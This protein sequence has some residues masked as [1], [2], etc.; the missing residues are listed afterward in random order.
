MKKILYAVGLSLVV[1][2]LLFSAIGCVEGPAGSQGEQGIQGATGEAGKD[3]ISITWFGDYPTA[4]M[5]NPNEND[6]YYNTTDGVSYI[7]DGGAWDVLV[8][9]GAAGTP[10]TWMG[11]AA[12]A[13]TSWRVLNYAYYNSTAGTSY[14][15]DGNS[16]EILAK[17]GTPCDVTRLAKLEAWAIALN[18]WAA[19]QP[20]DWTEYPVYAP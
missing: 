1:L 18:T 10:I 4:P 19:T 13:P 16:W 9:D 14:I 3:G 8:K 2:A 7:W 5:S 20:I 17:D 12:G 6:A 15:W 11:T